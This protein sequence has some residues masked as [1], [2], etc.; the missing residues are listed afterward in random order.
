MVDIKQYQNFQLQSVFG[1]RGPIT[2]NR[3]KILNDQAFGEVLSRTIFEE[4]FLETSNF[5][6]LSLLIMLGLGFSVL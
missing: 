3:P 4:T 6:L 5:F 1:R 2:R